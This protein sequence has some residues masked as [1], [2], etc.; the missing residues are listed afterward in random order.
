MQQ[1]TSHLAYASWMVYGLHVRHEF[2]H[3][4]PV[5]I[6][7]RFVDYDYLIKLQQNYDE[8]QYLVL[9]VRQQIVRTSQQKNIVFASMFDISD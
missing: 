1:E 2:H 3:K 6:S 9:L 7:D 8:Q 4:T 5:D